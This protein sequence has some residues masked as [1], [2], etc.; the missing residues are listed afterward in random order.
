MKVQSLIDLHLI[1]SWFKTSLK[2]SEEHVIMYVCI[3]QVLSG[4][5]MRLWGFCD[6]SNI[7]NANLTFL[8]EKGSDHSKVIL[9]HTSLLLSLVFSSCQIKNYVLEW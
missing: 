8:K 9:C 6:Q 2:V 5:L 1:L 7:K 4:Q 3:Y